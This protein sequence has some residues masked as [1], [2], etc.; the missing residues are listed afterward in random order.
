[1][2]LKNALPTIETELATLCAHHLA[3]YKI[4]RS[5]I[6]STDLLPTTSTGKVDKKILRKKLATA[7]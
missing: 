4:P 3:T 5:F 7:N 6:C 1:V 2:Q